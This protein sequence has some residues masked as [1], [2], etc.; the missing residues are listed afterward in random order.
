MFLNLYSSPRIYKDDQIREDELEEICKT[1]WGDEKCV[2]N[3][4]RSTLKEEIRC[5]PQTIWGY[6]AVYLKAVVCEY[7]D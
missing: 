3:F 2:D 7:V 5:D 6:I 4:I 1:R